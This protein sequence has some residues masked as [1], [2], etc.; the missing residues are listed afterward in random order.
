ML[1]CL[2]QDYDATTHTCA[3]PFYSAPEGALPTLSI[4]DAQSIGLAVALLW[5][6]AFGIRM[7]KRALTQI[8]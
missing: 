4:D 6:T 7:C 5:D 2:P 3:A 1:S 8:G